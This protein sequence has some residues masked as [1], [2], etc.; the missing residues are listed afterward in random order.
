MAKAIWQECGATRTRD[1]C[2]SFDPHSC[3]DWRLPARSWH[4]QHQAFTVLS[5][6]SG[7]CQKALVAALASVQLRRRSCTPP[8]CWPICQQQKP[9]PPSPKRIGKVRNRACWPRWSA[10]NNVRERGS[11]CPE[12]SASP[13]PERVGRKVL[14]RTDKSLSSCIV[15]EGWKR[16]SWDKNPRFFRPGRSQHWHSA[17]R[18]HCQFRRAFLTR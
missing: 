5:R 12:A 6:L 11:G 13:E 9:S 8:S 15:K 10:S 3:K 14:F 1:V 17:R 7:L 18:S 4:P 2:S 16:W